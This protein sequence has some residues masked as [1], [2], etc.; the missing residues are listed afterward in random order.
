MRGE[1]STL[2]TELLQLA[3]VLA[4]PPHPVQMHRQLPRHRHLGDLPS[5]AHGEVKELA[6]PLRL[7]ADGIRASFMQ[8]RVRP[9]ELSLCDAWPW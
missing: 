7:T 3:V 8:L 4:L 2:R 9:L 6:A 5:A 1:F